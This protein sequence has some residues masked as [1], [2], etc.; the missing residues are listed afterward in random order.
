MAAVTIHSA[1]GAQENEICHCF[2]FSLFYLPWSYG[3]GCHDRFF[4]CW[5]LNQPFHFHKETLQFLLTFLPLEWYP[6]QC[7]RCGFDPWVGKILWRRAW[8]PAPVFLSRKSHWQRS[9]V[10]YGPWGRKD[11]HMTEA[12]EHYCFSHFT[13]LFN[14]EQICWFLHLFFWPWSWNLQII[15]RV[16]PCITA[17]CLSFPCPFSCMFYL[18]V[19]VIAIFSKTSVK[20]NNNLRKE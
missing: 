17:R 18:E 2:H 11:W 14:N 12:T 6:V 13:K 9:L 16:F 1:F 7:R 15:F 5:I 20:K 4:Q 10:G 8:Q 3:A 19:K